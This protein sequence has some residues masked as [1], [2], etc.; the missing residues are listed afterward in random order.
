VGVVR[1]GS[2]QT[3][4][5]IAALRYENAFTGNGEG[6]ERNVASLPEA[7][8]KRKLIASPGNNICPVSATAWGWRKNANDVWQVKPER[9]KEPQGKVVCTVAGGEEKTLTHRCEAAGT[10]TR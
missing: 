7:C 9:P 3:V 10:D 6:D 5:E 4:E 8:D 2:V 1:K